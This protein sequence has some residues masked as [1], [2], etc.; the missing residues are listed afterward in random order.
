M[1]DEVQSYKLV[2]SGGLNSNQN[3]LYLAEAA[4]G[5][6][7]RLVNFEPSLY[8]GYRRIEGYGLLGNLN[9]TV[10]GS[11][12]EGPIL[13]LAIY[14]N[15]HLGNAYIIA[16]RKDVGANTYKLYKFVDNVGWQAITTGFTL[17]T[18]ANS[19]TVKKIRHTQFDFGSGSQIIFVDGVNNAVVFNGTNWY[20]LNSSNTGGSSSPGGDQIVN[21]PSIVEVFE[22]H[23]FLGGDVGSKAVIC[24]SKPL[25]PLNFMAADGANQ[26]TPGFNV[27]QIKPFRDDLFIFGINS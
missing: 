19:R 12:A 22:N 20:Q 4:S 24:H 16:A 1:P 11:S 23:I 14:K 9:V 21:A 18:T 8:G 17:A 5:S 10:G 6:A 15:E 25:D 2:C 3:H 26:I 27:V 7:T 13:G